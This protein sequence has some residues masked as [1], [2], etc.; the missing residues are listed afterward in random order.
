MSA[1]IQGY[2][3][4]GLCGSRRSGDDLADDVGAV[5]AV[6]LGE[7]SVLRC[8]RDGRVE[9]RTSLCRL[10]TVACAGSHLGLALGIVE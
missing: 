7:L 9:P 8:W 10:A 5:L 3:D 4:D 1:A 6:W 2:G